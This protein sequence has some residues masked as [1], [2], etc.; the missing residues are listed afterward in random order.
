MSVVQLSEEQVKRLLDWPL[1]CD[2]VEQAFRSVSDVRTNN[3]QP[4]SK[5]PA[6]SRTITDN[7]S[8]RCTINSFLTTCL[9]S[10]LT[11]IHRYSVLHAWLYWQFSTRIQH[12]S[13]A[14]QFFGL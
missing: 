5:Q 8:C 4:I 9:I 13:K 7:G 14:I 11:L 6:R 12:A 1:V 2:A 10:F 3:E